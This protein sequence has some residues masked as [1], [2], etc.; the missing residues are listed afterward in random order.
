M[1][2]QMQTQIDRGYL[3]PETR[4]AATAYL[5]RTGNADLLPILGLVDGPEPEPQSC[6]VCGKQVH[7]HGGCNRTK[8]CRAATHGSAVARHRLPCPA[9]GKP[10]PDPITNGGRKP[11]QNRRCEAGPTAR[12]VKR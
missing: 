5:T 1:T 9:C 12:G 2:G 10:L 8:E 3:T 7:S 6:P 11:C 4:A